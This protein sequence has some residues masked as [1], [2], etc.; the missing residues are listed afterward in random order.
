MVDDEPD[1]E[2]KPQ[3]LYKMLIE[4]NVFKHINEE[5]I[6]N[7]KDELQDII[8]EFPHKAQ[9][10]RDLIKRKERQN[11]CYNLMWQMLSF[12][13]REV[14]KELLIN[15]IYT[16]LTLKDSLDVV[17]K[18]NVL[19]QTLH[20]YGLDQESLVNLKE[21][22]KVFSELSKELR[23]NKY[24][25]YFVSR[26]KT[27]PYTNRE[28]EVN[29]YKFTPNIN[30]TKVSGA[31]KSNSSAT[32]LSGGNDYTD[33]SKE[34]SCSPGRFKKLYEDYKAIENKLNIKR[35]LK[36]LEEQKVCRFQP[37]TNK[38]YKK[39]DYIKPNKK[40]HKPYDSRMLEECTFVPN[41]EKYKRVS[42]S[43]EPLRSKSRIEGYTAIN[44]ERKRIKE[45]NERSA[46]GIKEGPFNLSSN[47]VK[48][49]NIPFVAIEITP[50]AGKTVK[51]NL[52]ATDDP[53]TVAKNFAEIYQLSEEDR[54]KLKE[55]LQIQLNDLT[56][57][58]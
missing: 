3:L 50:M 7:I 22:L 43:P 48:S 55:L 24:L 44:N 52:Y 25:I 32:Q 8:E 34:R 37:K 19:Q 14:T 31:L 39:Q 21:L 35:R 46:H 9:R 40:E 23:E 58:T 28:K 16:L 18:L 20:V 49:K 33:E 12:S 51:I 56:N 4:L 38:N 17:T 57:N 11:L 6:P 45:A 27:K 26:S 42:Q 53:Q 2:G 30:K 10:Q 36:H 5:Q 54:Y 15:L 29:E 1:I 41:I 13:D 47:V